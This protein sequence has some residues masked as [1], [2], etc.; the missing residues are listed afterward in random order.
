[1]KSLWEDV[2][3]LSYLRL[4]YTLR[5][6]IGQSAESCCSLPLFPA[7]QVK[8]LITTQISLVNQT[9]TPLF[10][11]DGRGGTVWGHLHPFCVQE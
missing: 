8:I 3:D 10:S 4:D 7:T 9:F 5:D 1:M 6:L 2:L 11:S